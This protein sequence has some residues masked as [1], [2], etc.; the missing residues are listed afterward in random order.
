MEKNVLLHHVFFLYITLAY[1]LKLG[2]KQKMLLLFSPEEVLYTINTNT[3]T[4]SSS[5][6]KYSVECF[7]DVVFTESSHNLVN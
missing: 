1:F 3:A 5:F 6:P 4:N 7:T 2:E